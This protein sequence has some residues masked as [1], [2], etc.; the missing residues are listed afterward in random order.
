ME[1]GVHQSSRN[2]LNDQLILMLLKLIEQAPHKLV[3]STDPSPPLTPQEHCHRPDKRGQLQQ[4]FPMPTVQWLTFAIKS[5]V[6]QVISD[7]GQELDS[8]SLQL[9]LVEMMADGLEAPEVAGLEVLK[10]QLSR[11]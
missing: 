3:V 1:L 8:A 2:L 10:D 4:H 7:V 5:L 11:F 6:V 9:V